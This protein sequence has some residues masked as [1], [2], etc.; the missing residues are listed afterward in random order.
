MTEK[1]GNAT[2]KSLARALSI[3]D[4]LVGENDS[5]GVRDLARMSHSSPATVYRSIST[6]CKTGF[7]E[8][9]QTDSKYRLGPKFM[10]LAESYTKQNPIQKV[11]RD[12]FI[13]YS[14]FFEHN[15]YMGK[16]LNNEVVYLTIIEGQGPIVISVS[17]GLSIDLFCSALGK[18]L[19]AHQEKDYINHYLNHTKLIKYTK[20]T[21]TDKNII[22]RELEKIKLSG[23]ALNN[24]ERHEEISAVG[25]ALA[26]IGNQTNLAISLAYPQH[27]VDTKKLIVDEIIAMAK[28]IAAEISHRMP[29]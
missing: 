12:V 24:G 23:Y 25:V 3:L 19:L 6:L 10:L 20:T 22:L 9:D 16:I 13:S 18:A 7:L 17:P 14:K 2:N 1:C 5:L 11:A 28:D 26:P 29:K 4:L 27:Y 8:K 21:I 15:F